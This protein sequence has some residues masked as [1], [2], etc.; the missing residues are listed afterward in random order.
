MGFEHVGNQQRG[1]RQ[2]RREKMEPK[3]K[4]KIFHAAIHNEPLHIFGTMS[5]L[6]ETTL[7]DIVIDLDVEGSPELS[8]NV[9]K[10]AKA[11]Y[12]SQTLVYNV[13][14]NRFCQLGDPHGDGS[15]GACI[16][17]L[18]SS[19]GSLEKVL[20]SNQR[21][22]KSSMGRPLTLEQR[23]EKGRVVA[24]EMNGIPDT[25]GS[26][27]LIT[28]SEG[29]DMALD[30]YS[31]SNIASTND[32]PMSQQIFRSVGVVRE[33]EKDVLGQVA[34]TYCDADGRPYADIRVIRALVVDDP[35][36]DPEGMD[37]L[38]DARGVVFEGDRVIASP[39]WER[40]ADEKVEHRIS[41]DQVDPLT[42]E[43]DL[44]KVRQCEEEHLKKQDKSRAVVLE[45]LGDLPSAEVTAPD[46]VL[47]V[48]KLNP[49]TEDEDLELI[50]SRFDE[51]VKAEIIR[52][53][54]TGN[55][56]H[57]AFVE[58]T[59]KEQAVE[60]YF[61]MNNALVDDRRI[62]VDF[63]QSVAKVWDKFNQRMKTNLGGRS[64]REMPT[65]PYGGRYS[66]SSSRGP[67]QLNKHNQRA[68]RETF[69]RNDSRHQRQGNRA[70]QEDNLPGNDR[71]RHDRGYVEP[72]SDYAR[73]ER[74]RETDR[75]R[76]PHSQSGLH[77]RE[78]KMEVDQFGRE[79]R[80]SEI[81]EPTSNHR[82]DS[83]S[84]EERN[85]NNEFRAHTHRKHDK[86]RK[87]HRKRSRKQKRHR[88]DDQSECSSSLSNG[89]YEDGRREEDRKEYSD[90]NHYKRRHADGKR[91]HHDDRRRSRSRDRGR[92]ERKHRA[93]DDRRHRSYS[94][95]ETEEA[96]YKEKSR[97]H[98]SPDNHSNR[99]RRGIGEYRE[100]KSN[101]RKRSR[102]D[103]PD[104]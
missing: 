104:T 101:H 40:P 1:R 96:R 22:L 12:Y 26:Q 78:I 10:L 37:R 64:N 54:D 95:G 18:I 49:I 97:G 103:S 14:V 25:I 100:E 48:C 66:G 17:G 15:G 3:T 52:D 20:K 7:G 31:S 89:K 36:E 35:F 13:Q 74:Y 50:F 57:Y 24:T 8:K 75:E 77:E 19:E 28:T 83:S 63:S 21:F 47:F 43:E 42:G 81:N 23:R 98:R 80:R 45:M 72:R 65:D 67:R 62:K 41:A 71:C 32:G 88:K 34:S 39:E 76:K 55:S 92:S 70:S 87:H 30:G 84:R 86:E 61:K 4:L 9:L 44:E 58:F 93:S 85:R 33:D 82:R 38:Y 79:L 94:R 59:K 51:K 60:A 91:K 102:H 29:Q 99:R 2:D 11:R 27:L 69:P 16:Q 5:I 68:G 46:N 56:L 6:L 53:N 90:E 73:E